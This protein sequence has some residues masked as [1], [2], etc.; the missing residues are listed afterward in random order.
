M[1]T[2][3]IV[4]VKHLSEA[5]S[6]L[7]AALVP[8]QRRQL[9]LCMLADVLD[10]LGK[11][12]VARV[13]VVSPD[14]EVLDFADTHGAAGLKEPRVGLNGALRLAISHAMTKGATSVLIVPA[15]VPAIK[16]SDVEKILEMATTAR[17][18]VIAPSNTNG[19]N[20]LLLRPPNV[21]DVHFGGESF[22]THLAEACRAGVVPRIYRSPT[23]A[24]DIDVTADLA[25]IRAYGRGT[26]MYDFLQSL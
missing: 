22:P 7:G 4:P 8:E 5:K 26:R 19:T 16:T 25:S 12:S 2:W 9:V 13:V 17:E 24:I 3:A 6:S 10:V 23:T 14:D 18:V 21:M 11:T 15:D 20:A 1:P